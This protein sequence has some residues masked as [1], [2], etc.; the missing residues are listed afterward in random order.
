[1]NFTKSFKNRAF[2][3]FFLMYFS[4]VMAL[5]FTRKGYKEI[6][7]QDVVDKAKTLGEKSYQKPDRDSIPECLKKIGYDQWMDISYNP[8]KSL[9]PN[10]AFKVQFFHRGYIFPEAVTVHYVDKIGIHTMPFSPDLFNYKKKN[11][12]DQVNGDI[13]FSGFR[14]HYQ[15][16]SPD[17]QDELIS[18]L[19]ASYFRALG[20]N[21]FYG[22]SARGLAINTGE[23]VGEEFPFFKEFWIIRPS[24]F[25][26]KITVYALMDSESLTGAYEFLIKPGEQT[27]MD[28]KCT[29]FIRKSVR[30]LGIAP[31]TSMFCFGEHSDEKKNGDF[32]PEVHDS[33]GLLIQANSGEWIWHPLINPKR[34]LTNSFSGGQPIG[35]GLMQRDTNF[36]H[37]QDFQARYGRRPSAW[38]EPKSDW[39]AGHVELFQ[40]PTVNEYSDNIGAYWVPEKSYKPGEALHFE[41]SLSWCSPIHRKPLL[42]IVNSTRILRKE[43]DVR[44]I[45]DFQSDRKKKSLFK[46]DLTADIQV[47]NGYRLLSSQIIENPVSK[48]LRLVIHV[49]FDKKGFLDEIIPDELPAIDLIA[50]IKDKDKQITETW[51]YTYL[52]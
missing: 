35:F 44:F 19:G 40:F 6:C 9:W 20:K 47:L 4:E 30:K 28:V 11:Y 46:K 18:F 14:I 48:G 52:P 16:N 41:Y 12:S 7:F 43:K 1:M 8:A 31:L 2:I 21:H 51:S 49:R 32:R 10:D 3:F 45:I 22:L 5:S 33:D 13:G 37:Y 15:F 36:D 34:I 23:D 42:A 39:G 25:S 27:V 17:F 38:V 50:F 29:I 24:S 26:R